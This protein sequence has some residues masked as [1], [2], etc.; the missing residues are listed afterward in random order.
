[1]SLCDGVSQP[2]GCTWVTVR[3]KKYVGSGPEW[4]CINVTFMF[5]AV[6]YLICCS[7]CGTVYFLN[8]GYWVIQSFISGMHQYE[9]VD[10]DINLQ[11]GRFWATSVAS[12][13]ERFIDFRSCWVFFI[14]VVQG[15]PGG[16]L[17]FSK[18][19][20]L[21]YAWHLICLALVAAGCHK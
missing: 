9:C 12:F 18:G 6:T 2:T 4:A 21:R 10:V 19:K 1:M 15:H 5:F 16:L 14:H 7:R 11:S 17:Q 20:L 13:M 8:F 3:K